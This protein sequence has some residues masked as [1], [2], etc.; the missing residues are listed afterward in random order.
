MLRKHFLATLAGL[1]LTP[2]ALPL[3]AQDHSKPLEWVVGYAAGGGSDIVARTIAESM[4]ASLGRPVII[5]N[6]PGAGTNIAA[7]YA[8]RNKDFGNLIFSA[9]FA[10]LA[11]NPFLFSKLSYNAEKDFQ[12]VGLLVRFPMFL[13]VSNNVP[14]K[15]LKEFMAWAKGNADG[16]NW[17]SAGPGSPHHLVGELFREQSG[18]KLTHV[19]Y[20]G[21]APAIQDV[22][23]GQVPAMWIDSATVYPF[24]ATNK[25][26]AIGVASPQRVATMPDV[27]TI[28]EQGLQG[29]EGYAWQGLVAPTGT[30]AEAVAQFSKALQT[31]LADTR[32]RAR[33]Q[34]LGVEPL[35]GTPAQMGSYARAEREK[36][37]R[38]ITKVGVKLD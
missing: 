35:P 34:A 27:A 31:A 25:V 33:L 8:A 13:V 15:N 9:D 17:A 10:T 23:G 18:L 37:G 2:L 6:K 7:D 16:V 24:L 32:T 4:G 3:H 30:S 14:A 1:A 38:V 29:F 12:P 36:W 19:P 21:A 26:R 22:I 28:Q 11:A 5:N 20:R